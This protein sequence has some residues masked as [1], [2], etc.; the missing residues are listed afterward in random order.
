M[1]EETYVSF[2]TAKLLKEKG[3]KEKCVNLYDFNTGKLVENYSLTVYN[4]EQW[5]SFVTAPTHQMVLKWLRDV[6]GILISVS[7]Y[8]NY[9][10]ETKHY[11]SDYGSHIISLS[12]HDLLCDV[13][14]EA[15]TY[16]EA[17]E[18]AITYCLTK[19]I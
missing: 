6:H 10:D 16:E 8:V 9:D 14:N 4:N 3:F 7:T 11:W 1:I 2:E 17:T 15:D 19:L 12:K 13:R 5:G 18:K